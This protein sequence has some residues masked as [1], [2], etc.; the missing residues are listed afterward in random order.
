MK[1]EEKIG[2]VRNIIENKNHVGMKETYLKVKFPDE[3]NCEVT[4]LESMQKNE[5]GTNSRK[6]SR[7][8]RA[9]CIKSQH[10]LWIS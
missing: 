8:L 5:L 10:R 6:K 2:I 1:F 7:K 9:R 4:I 3:Q